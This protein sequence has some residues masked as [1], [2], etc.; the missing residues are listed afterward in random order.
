MNQGVLA[1]MHCILQAGRCVTVVVIVILQSGNLRIWQKNR[2]NEHPY[3]W[4]KLK[5]L[6]GNIKVIKNLLHTL[7]FVIIFWNH[8]SALLLSVQAA[9]AQQI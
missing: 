5:T 7:S 2:E 3:S 8:F 6:S 4:L 1:T 9:L